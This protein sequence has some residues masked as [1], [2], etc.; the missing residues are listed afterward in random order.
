MPKDVVIR[1]HGTA[2]EYHEQIVAPPEHVFLVWY[3]LGKV[4]SLLGVTKTEEIAAQIARSVVA[5][6]N[7]GAYWRQVAPRVW[8]D[9]N[10]TA[11]IYI[12]RRG[13]AQ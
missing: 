1:M 2:A 5:G 6:F 7:Q 11:K 8:T 12:D 9:L 4:P 10:H 13:V 3:E